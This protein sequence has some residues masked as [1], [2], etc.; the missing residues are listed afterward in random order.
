ATAHVPRHADQPSIYGSVFFTNIARMT[1]EIKCDTDEQTGTSI[2]GLFNRKAN[3][4]RHAPIGL[5]F[6]HDPRSQAIAVTPITITDQEAFLDAAPIAAQIRHYLKDGAKTASRLAEIL[7]KPVDTIL[8]TLHR[9][10]EKGE[11]HALGS[12][13]GTE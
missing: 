11:F 13:R 6:A 12:G 10:E 8:K 9:G 2:L 5:Q 7:G 1:W 4:R 3:E